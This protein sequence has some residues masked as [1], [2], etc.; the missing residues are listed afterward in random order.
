MSLSSGFIIKNNCITYNY[1][2]SHNHSA[3]ENTDD[4]NN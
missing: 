4:M 3:F 1:V 2:C